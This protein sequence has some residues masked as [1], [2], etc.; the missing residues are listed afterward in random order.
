MPRP[1]RSR[2]KYTYATARSNPSEDED[3]G[4]DIY[5]S[6]H[7]SNGNNSY[8]PNESRMSI[9]GNNSMATIDQLQYVAAP[10]HQA[11]SPHRYMTYTVLFI[12]FLWS[13]RSSTV[14]RTLDYFHL[15]MCRQHPSE[16]SWL[17]ERFVFPPCPCELTMPVTDYAVFQ[18]KTQ[19]FDEIEEQKKD[20]TML[21]PISANDNAVV[22]WLMQDIVGQD[23]A[24][25]MIS[26]Y[27]QSWLGDASVVASSAVNT[28]FQ[29]CQDLI[30]GQKPMSMIL[31]G[32][33]GVGKTLT[34]DRIG[35]MLMRECDWDEKGDPR[36]V[37]KLYGADYANGHKNDVS[38]SP[39][40]NAR[41][42]GKIDA[43]A[44]NLKSVVMDTRTRFVR[45][46]VDH[47]NANNHNSGAVIVISEMEKMS[48]PVLDALAKAFD[49][50]TLS[51]NSGSS[52]ETTVH[53]ADLSKVL[54]LFATNLCAEEI[55]RSIQ[56][57]GGVEHIS[58]AALGASIRKHYL[59]EA[60][61][62]ELELVKFLGPVIPFLPLSPNHMTTILQ[63][64]L[65]RY[66]DQY[67]NEY[68][69]RLEVSNDFIHYFST[70]VEYYEIRRRGADDIF[71]TFA[72]DGARA[73]DDPVHAI[74][75][76]VA[77]FRQ[78]FVKDKVAKLDYDADSEEAWLQICSGG[79]KL[80]CTLVGRTPFRFDDA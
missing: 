46:I 15:R 32:S 58:L 78:H 17:A 54:F 71:F 77:R 41:G 38:S 51:Y 80:E 40:S 69:R 60:W 33:N 62:D 45:D 42:D 19:L 74:R 23:E 2:A 48:A 25:T 37:L 30:Y 49:G 3:D 65:K 53:S 59:G 61:N 57:Q 14:H 43:V 21:P 70:D 67:A 52:G 12:S 16:R 34:A 6:N 56:E 63:R 39:S 10:F 76:I 75:A 31:T 79:D 11:P 36:G 13:I 1:R 20:D 29:D 18:N 64:R 26:D 66:S 44:S 55:F 47:L 27:L 72:M 7:S 5:N 8:D 22:N 73:L 28:H 35:K 9:W 24:L 4:D 50:S 68:W